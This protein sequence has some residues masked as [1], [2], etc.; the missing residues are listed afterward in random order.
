MYLG[1]YLI[2]I[3]ISISLLGV[4][5]LFLN[6]FNWFS[7]LKGDF[8]YESKSLKIYFPFM[9]MLILSIILTF[10]INLFNKLFK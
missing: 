10:F 3:G 1:K 9:S 6:N 7:N 5:V 4:I 2:T 8:I